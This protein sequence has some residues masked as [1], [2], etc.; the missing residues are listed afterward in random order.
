MAKV[1]NNGTEVAAE[2]AEAAT[3]AATK[4]AT[5]A[6]AKSKSVALECDTKLD[7]GRRKN[8]L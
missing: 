3:K 4:A 6:I 8:D 7:A 1:A 5:T 2:V